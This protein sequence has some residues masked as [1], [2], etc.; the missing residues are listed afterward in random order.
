MADRGV[1]Q[2]I[3]LTNAT[4]I[5]RTVLPQ[6]NPIKQVHNPSIQSFS[7]LHSELTYFPGI[8]I[9]SRLWKLAN[10]CAVGL[11]AD[12]IFVKL[13]PEYISHRRQ[14]A[15]TYTYTHTYISHSLCILITTENIS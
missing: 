8:Q 11:K 13:L 4:V 15:Y 1:G 5:G 10:P 9:I 2:L 3:K 7:Y 12:L 6:I 14:H